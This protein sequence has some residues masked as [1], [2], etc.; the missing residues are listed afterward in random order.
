MQNLSLLKTNSQPFTVDSLLS[1]NHKFHSKY[2]LAIFLSLTKTKSYTPIAGCVLEHIIANNNL[3][4]YEKLYY[5]LADSLAL[6]SK[7]KG[8]NRVAAL[9]STDWAKRLGCSRS[10]VFV[11]QQSLAQKGYF[12][13]DK[14]FDTKGRN[15]RN[16]VTPTLPSAVFNHL[17]NKH[18]SKAEV[19]TLYNPVT[20][21]KRSYLDRTKLFIKLNYD[22]LKIITS[23]Q[24]L[25]PRQKVIWIGFYMRCYKNY[26]IQNRESIKVSKYNLNDASIYDVFS[27]V[28]SYKEIAATHSCTT[29]Y[30]SK[31]IRMLEGLGFI[32]SENFYIRNKHSD[33]CDDSSYSGSDNIQERQDKSLWKIAITL[34]ENF[35]LELERAK[36]RSNLKLQ[37]KKDDVID[38]II[39]PKLT[40]NCLILDGIKVNLDL[41]QASFIKSAL[42]V[43]SNDNI[44]KASSYSSSSINFSSH[45]YTEHVTGKPDTI[46]E[47]KKVSLSNI[48]FRNI[49]P[50][51][52]DNNEEKN[53]IIKSNPHVAKSGLLLNKYFLSKIKDTKSNL[54]ASHKVLFDKFLMRF[55]NGADKNID[56]T[57]NYNNNKEKE[58]NIYSELIRRKIKILPKDKADKA[59]R[60]AYSLVSKGLTKGYTAS[61]TKHELAKQLIY[62]A[63]TWKPTKLGTSLSRE[64]EIDTAL[65]VAWKA[66]V[67]GTWKVPLEIAKAE[68]LQ[69]EFKHYKRKYQESGILSHEAKALEL[70]VNNMLGG[71]SDL[72]GKITEGTKAIDNGVNFDN[73]AIEKNNNNPLDY[74]LTEMAVTEQNSS[75]YYGINQ[76]ENNLINQQSNYLPDYEGVETEQSKKLCVNLS[77]I[78]DKQK[79]LK[80][81]SNDKDD[82][83]KL[84]TQGSNE[85]FVKLKELYMNEEREWVITLSHVT[86]DTFLKLSSDTNLLNQNN[87]PIS[88]DLMIKGAEDQQE[89]MTQEIP[90]QNG[91]NALDKA[92]F[93]SVKR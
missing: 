87:I 6:I 66:I 68:I 37:D 29:K 90:R 17:N 20:E 11:M 13:I 15:K 72:I 24:Y 88:E 51:P 77:H 30:L 58:F 14:D 4:D 41:E 67:S 64:K 63:A 56:I 59:R 91:F 19:Y 42:F 33:N 8:N 61:L 50:E 12:I 44:D 81:V 46:G 62:H 5:I 36:N 54:G 28:S 93:S 55:N 92:L 48:P 79:Y 23:N 16:L 45:E 18:P 70:D 65:S 89:T 52:F 57:N 78:P 10:L 80:A 74:G 53:S 43:D 35:L 76:P 73:R 47:S 9:A 83:L 22:L 21:C 40:E 32:K 31:S 1:Y 38:N 60:F 3:T 34:P 86:K 84:E 49:T 25:N 27:F 85:Y 39:N 71:W 75:M 7:N 26:M 69:Y 82:I 2:N